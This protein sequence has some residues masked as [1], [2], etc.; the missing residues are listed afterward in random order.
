MPFPGGPPDRLSGVKSFAPSSRPFGLPIPFQT[1]PRRGW[2]GRARLLLLTLGGVTL[3][4]AGCNRG[5][6]GAMAGPLAI[7]VGAIPG[8]PNYAQVV[9][10]VELAVA[11]LNEQGGGPRFRVRLPDSTA[12][13]AVRV[14]QQLRED[15]TVI[16]V[17]GHPES[18][19][20]LEAIPVYA[21][22]EHDGANG[23][24]AISPTSSSP[25]LSGISPWFFR[26]SPSDANAAMYT[27][28]WVLDS[29]RA[30]R[31]AIVYRNDSYGRDWA[32]TFAQTF[33]Q[34]RG[35]VVMRDPYLTGVVEFDAYAALIASLAP[36]V[37]LFPGDANDALELMRA[38]RRKGVSVPFIGGDGT[39][40]MKQDTDAAGARYVAFFDESRASSKEAQYFLPEYKARFG[41]APDMFAA[42]AYDAAIVVG[43]TVA[44][45]VR[46]R[47]ALRLALEQVGN[48]APSVDG[49]AGRIAFEK[50]H[51][52][53]GRTVVIARVPGVP[54]SGQPGE[55]G[56]RP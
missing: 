35:A 51:D 54:P 1:P 56:G 45:G 44:N 23:V 37:L 40:T 50:N 22:T 3:S 14:A 28:Q 49:V 7:G 21:D 52:I 38:L 32:A 17:V 18:G 43:R 12:N 33:E 31:A 48:G 26:V 34:G 53:K 36:D 47:A 2:N 15:P 24:V 42:L 9:Q 46:T 30:R 10:G 20:T 4:S 8:S 19:N 55:Q 13:S 27:A 16:A 25:R 11:R 5:D 6:D 41:R 29:L 39:E